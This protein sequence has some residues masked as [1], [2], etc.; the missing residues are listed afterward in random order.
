[1]RV[2]RLLPVV[3][4]ILPIGGGLWLDPTLPDRIPRHF[5][6]TG[7]ADAYWD[8]TLFRWLLLP[9][10]GLFSAASVYV[11][12]WVVGTVPSS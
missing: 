5:E 3:L 10:V 8:T 4:L 11:P 6:F 1:M 2:P 12:I 9:L 7:P